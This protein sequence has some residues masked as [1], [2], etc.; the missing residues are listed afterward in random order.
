M[1]FQQS[2]PHC[3]CHSRNNG[4]LMR[5]DGAYCDAPAGG[6]ESVG[7]HFFC[8]PLVF[9]RCAASS[10]AIGAKHRGGHIFSDWLE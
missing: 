7:L 5:Q 6:P 1:K 3:W 10:L 8:S 9:G 4:P 2:I